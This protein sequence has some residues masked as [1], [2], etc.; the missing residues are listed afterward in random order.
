MIML[1]MPWQL[2]ELLGIKFENEPFSIPR[3]GQAR[4]ANLVHHEFANIR[5]LGTL[6]FRLPEIMGA[7]S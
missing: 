7:E 3:Q 1:T 4:H 6:K 2:A 5:S